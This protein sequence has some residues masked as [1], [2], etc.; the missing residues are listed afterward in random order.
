MGKFLEYIKKKGGEKR[1]ASNWSKW[2][3]DRRT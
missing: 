2:K 1:R 3:K